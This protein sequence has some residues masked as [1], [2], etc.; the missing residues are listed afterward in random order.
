[1]PIAKATSGSLALWAVAA[2]IRELR[3]VLR[4]TAL[5]IL[6]I[7]EQSPMGGF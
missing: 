1:M 3:T 4:S 2:D 6:F 7:R 5:P